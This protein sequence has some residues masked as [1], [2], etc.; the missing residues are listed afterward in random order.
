MADQPRTRL[1]SFVL[2]V[3]VLSGAATMAAPAESPIAAMNAAISHLERYDYQP[4]FDGFQALA[5]EYPRWEAAHVNL[6]LAALNLQ[7]KKYL[8]IARESFAKVLELNPRSCHALLSLGIIDRHESRSAAA[9]S[10]LERAVAIDPDDPWL[11]YY[12]GATLTDL[13]RWEDAR[14]YLEDALLMQPSFASALYRL[15]GVYARLGKEGRAKRIDLLRRFQRLERGH[16]GLKAGF[17]YGEG[18]RYN[19]AIRGTAPPGWAAPKPWTPKRAPQFGSPRALLH[20]PLASSDVPAMALGDVTGDGSLETVVCG[21]R[22]TIVAPSQAGAAV[23]ARLEIGADLCALGDLDGDR[24]LDLVCAGRDGLRLLGNDGAGNFG[25]IEA[26]GID[27]ASHGQ[28]R[29]LLLTDADSDWDLD[30]VALWSSGLQVLNND[31]DGTWRDIT[32]ECGFDKLPFA[33]TEM[34]W[35]D[36]DGDVDVDVVLLDGASGKAGV[37]ANDRLWT[38]RAIESATAGAPATGLVSTAGGDLD[39]DGDLDLVLFCGDSLR[40]WRGDGKLGFAE[41]RAFAERH[42]AVGGTAGV[43]FD[44]RGAL[45]ASL[46]VLDGRIEAGASAASGPVFLTASVD[47]PAAVSLAG[48]SLARGRVAGAA[49]HITR[50]GPPQLIVA[51]ATRGLTSWPIVA[52]GPWLAVDLRGPG[53]KEFEKKILR[54]NTAGIGATVE[55]RAGV[56]R[57]VAQLG[58]GCGGTVREPSR[59]SCGLAGRAVAD[60]VRI[61]WPDAVLQSEMALAAGRLHALE[62]VERKPSSCPVLFAWNGERFEFVADF[63]GVGGLGY[64]HAPGSY[65]EPDPTEILALPQLRERD[66]RWELRALE[67]LEEC[68]YLDAA[69]L[70]VVDH[71]DDVTVLPLEMFAVTAPAPGF[72]LLAFREPVAPTRVVDGAGRDVTAQMRAVDRSYAPDLRRDGRFPGVLDGE[73]S[74]ILEFD[75]AIDRLIGGAGDAV[76]RGGDDGGLWLFLHGYIEYGYSTSNFAAWQAELAPRAPTFS[77][78]RDG[79]WVALREEWGFPAGYPRWMAVD[80]EGLLAAGD[81]RIR[82]DTGFE[83]AWDTAFLGCAVRFPAVTGEAAGPGGETIRVREL[84]PERA[85][86]RF[87]GFVAPSNPFD[88]VEGFVYDRFRSRDHYR[89]MPGDFTRFGPVGELLAETDDRFVVFGPGDEIVLSFDAV[90]A[91]KAGAPA[92]RSLFWK[93]TG[94]CKDT[95]LYTGHPDRVEPLPFRGMSSYPFAPGEAPPERPAIDDYRRRWNTRRLVGD[96]RTPCRGPETVTSPTSD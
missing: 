51:D 17:K 70:L 85:T 41:D 78:E 47:A 45:E 67:P 27:A 42:G 62:E 71:P 65:G 7:E 69:S 30:I 60:Y 4:A 26:V 39:G 64:F 59:L 19:L 54:S 72:E 48:G 87:R 28:P 24:D 80:L 31:G 40:L 82:I 91:G 93:C 37:W 49:A 13:R 29:R 5:R 68:T 79:R 74:V 15:G 58:T 81:R 56:R 55:V 73:H 2:T 61:L 32:A 75:E 6:G 63:L 88:D 10:S 33:P 44:F 92:R 18:G 90:S 89:V 77:V 1:T 3:V 57:V 23:L 22:V 50:A 25:R 46:L 12:A 86:L 96:A 95:D 11:Q 20:G 34:V 38:F 16:V 76:R 84:A 9:L 14:K 36:L 52:D 21:E 94:Y 83:I 53:L 8:S 43:V 66:G 35:A